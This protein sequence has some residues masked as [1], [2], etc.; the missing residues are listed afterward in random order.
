MPFTAQLF[1]STVFGFSLWRVLRTFAPRARTL[2]IL[3][4]HKKQSS[5]VVLRRIEKRR[6]MRSF[7][8][9]NDTFPITFSSRRHQLDRTKSCLS[10]QD[11]EFLERP[12]LLLLPSSLHT[13]TMK[14]STLGLSESPASVLTELYLRA[15]NNRELS[16]VEFIA[17]LP[18]T[19]HKNKHSNNTAQDLVGNLMEYVA[20]CIL[21]CDKSFVS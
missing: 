15:S 16:L 2:L 10:Q 4:L 13:I 11:S 6:M 8:G 17:A 5:R 19:I 1:F 20:L 9:P 14:L 3:P 18:E 12:Y 21:A 7:R